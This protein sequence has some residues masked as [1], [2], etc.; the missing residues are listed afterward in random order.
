MGKGMICVVSLE[1][2]PASKWNGGGTSNTTNNFNSFRNNENQKSDNDENFGSR[3]T[4][5]QIFICF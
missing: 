1:P 2:A 5:K 4:S 3:N